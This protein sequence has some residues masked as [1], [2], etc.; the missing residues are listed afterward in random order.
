[1]AAQIPPFIHGFHDDQDFA[2]VMA[3]TRGISRF[4]DGPTAESRIHFRCVRKQNIEYVRRVHSRV[5]NWSRRLARAELRTEQRLYFCELSDSLDS[6]IYAPS[7]NES[8][9]DDFDCGALIDR[10]DQR[11]QLSQACSSITTQSWT[12]VWTKSVMARSLAIFCVGTLPG[13]VG[14]IRVPQLAVASLDQERCPMGKSLQCRKRVGNIDSEQVS[15]K[16]KPARGR[17]YKK[18]MDQRQ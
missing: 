13:F 18:T 2:T 11:D 10:A 9:E 14:P 6:S 15:V 1:M 7:I 17:C 5:E 16:C 12:L 4:G 8:D 3:S